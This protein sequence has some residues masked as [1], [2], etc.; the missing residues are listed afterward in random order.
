MVPRLLLALALVGSTWLLQ[1]GPAWAQ[2]ATTDPD[3]AIP[4]GAFFTE[5][6]PGRTDGAGFAVLDGHGVRFWS[7]FQ[8]H[9]GVFGLGYPTS[10]RFQWGSQVAQAFEKGVLR[11]KDDAAE[12][13][14]VPPTS[15]PG[16]KPPAY[17]LEAEQPPRAAAEL[18]TKPWS[19]WWWPASDRA[20][21]SLLT[22]NSPL[23][24]YDQYVE[25]A[26][27][28]NPATRAWER[29]TIYFPNAS[30]AGH[31]NGFAAAA[32]LEPEPTE[33]RTILGITFTVADQK[34]LLTDY[35]FGDGVA[36]SYGAD[37]TVSPADFHR[38]L[39]D[40]LGTN[41]KGFVLTYDMGGG[42]VWSYPVY[43][44]QS[45]WWMDP[46]TTGLWRVRTTVWMADMDV[47]PNF[48][49]LQPYPGPDG[50]TFEY[51]LVDDPR[52]PTGGDWT[53]PS[54]AGRFAHPG[55]IWYP[56]PKVRNADRDLTSPG[57]DLNVV[58][59]ILAGAPADNG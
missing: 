10:R 22:P 37:G 13:E 46:D 28:D 38:T 44:F 56:N 26:T 52:H 2:S 40:W 32:L 21:P 58:R 20:G 5:A 36:W 18:E 39:L 24:K 59:T 31:C 33:P 53:G 45:E 29:Q 57:L 50:K 7:A 51:T 48:V 19:G 43:K 30:W 34:A 55:Q 8:D 15:L 3:Y 6:L 16:G 54:A 17:A 27:G 4:G 42:E 47:P 1:V 41:G 23:D 9:G 49:G 35:H 14:V 12:A 11:W 25:T